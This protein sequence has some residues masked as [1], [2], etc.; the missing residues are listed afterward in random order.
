METIKVVKAMQNVDIRDALSG[1]ALRLSEGA[2]YELR[3]GDA[4]LVS[5]P[6][7]F[8]PCEIHRPGDPRLVGTIDQREA[9]RLI[10]NGMLM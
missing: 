8:Y 9:G 6:E 2:H 5:E 7:K 4:H 1:G 3:M 10:A